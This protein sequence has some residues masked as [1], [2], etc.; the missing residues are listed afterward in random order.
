MASASLPLGFAAGDLVVVGDRPQAQRVAIDVGVGLPVLSL[1]A[2]L[3]P[4]Q[5]S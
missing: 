2:R 4:P 3:R 1:S 5:G